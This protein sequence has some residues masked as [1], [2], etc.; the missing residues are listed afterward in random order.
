MS[1]PTIGTIQKSKMSVEQAVCYTLPIPPAP[2]A[3]L[4]A[5]TQ[6][7]NAAWTLTTQPPIPVNLVLVFVDTNLSLTVDPV[8][9]VGLDQDGNPVTEVFAYAGIGSLTGLI[10][11]S[12]VVSVTLSDFATIAGADETLQ[13]LTGT[14]IGLPCGLHGKLVRVIKSV[15]NMADEAVGTVNA[16]YRTI[17]PTNAPAADHNILFYYLVA[18]DLFMG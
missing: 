9:V 10:A 5:A 1:T 3:E 2:A 6:I 11:F 14:K 8:T 18:Y 12:K 15:H 13:I 4:K 7:A 16:T 17:I